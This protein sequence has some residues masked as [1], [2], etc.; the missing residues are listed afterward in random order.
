MFL[1]IGIGIFRLIG[2]GLGSLDGAVSAVRVGKAFCADHPFRDVVAA[3]GCLSTHAHHPR[4]IGIPILDGK[5]I[6]DIA[7]R[8]RSPD[9]TA[10]HAHAFIGMS[11]YGPVDDI[12]VVDMLLHDVISRQPGQK[13]PVADLPLH[14]SPVFSLV[15]GPILPCSPDPKR[16]HVPVTLA[17]YDL[18][19]VSVVH[20]F[21]DF[22]IMS[23]MAALGSS[24]DAQSFFL[25]QF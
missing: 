22:Q 5:M 14:I 3:S 11:A 17:G 15:V 24:H 2:E 13:E 16:S 25:G 6:E 12:Q 4:S 7:E 8:R 10:T 9:L 19:D 1:D 20:P 18:T 23:L 21:H